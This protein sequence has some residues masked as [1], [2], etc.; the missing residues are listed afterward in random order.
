MSDDDY[1]IKG[2]YTYAGDQELRDAHRWGGDAGAGRELAHRD[3]RDA[4]AAGSWRGT[5]PAPAPAPTVQPGGR[6]GD[7]AFLL[8]ALLLAPIAILGLVFRGL[9]SGVDSLTYDSP[10][11]FLFPVPGDGTARFAL[12]LITLLLLIPGSLLWTSRRLRT[13]RLRPLGTWVLSP[14]AVLLVP[15]VVYVAVTTFTADVVR[16]GG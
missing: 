5:A 16:L 2:M 6:I 15:V 3:R 7:G 13:T 1:Q 4:E 8:S 14:A 10:L 12:S 9:A 11:A